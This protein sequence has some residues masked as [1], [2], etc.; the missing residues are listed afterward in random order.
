MAIR[1]KLVTKEDGTAAW[2]SRTKP[3][4]RSEGTVQTSNDQVDS[5]D[6]VYENLFVHCSYNPRTFSYD[7]CAP[8]PRFP[9][10]DPE[11]GTEENISSDESSSFATSL[12]DGGGDSSGDGGVGLES[13]SSS[14][15]SSSYVSSSYSSSSYYS[16]S[17]SY[18]SSSSSNT[19]VS[20]SN[21][22]SSS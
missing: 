11:C 17:S 7:T 1:L 18:P 2:F 6:G 3:S 12:D 19:S 5:E 13:S 8:S 20:T 21:G 14:S 9:D 10:P 4:Y 15:I 16:S 22:S